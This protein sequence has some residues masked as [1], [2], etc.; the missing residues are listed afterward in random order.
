MYT[1]FFCSFKQAWREN[2]QLGIRESSPSSAG[3]CHFTN[4]QSSV[5]ASKIDYNPGL[6]YGIPAFDYWQYLVT[7]V[8]FLCQ[9]RTPD[10]G[11]V[12]SNETKLALVSAVSG[13]YWMHV[14]SYVKGVLT[15]LGMCYLWKN[16][17]DLSP[18]LPNPKELESEEK[19]QKSLNEKQQ[20]NLRC[21]WKSIEVR[22]QY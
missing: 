10:N 2:I 18:A 3:T 15:F 12:A 19:P 17:Q 6:N 5:C 8:K 16:F 22:Y 4:C 14:P 9:Q 20:V 11:N 21:I 1:F 13:I 7:F